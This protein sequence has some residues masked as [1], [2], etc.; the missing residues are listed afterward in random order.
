MSDIKINS[1]QEISKET[2][3]KFYDSLTDV[4]YEYL[5]YNSTIKGNL[6]LIEI[7]KV[8][9]DRSMCFIKEIMDIAVSITQ[10]EEGI[11]EQ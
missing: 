3:Q 8:I 7:V 5:M 4:I 1:K 2:L 11:N 9:R 6:P 10:I